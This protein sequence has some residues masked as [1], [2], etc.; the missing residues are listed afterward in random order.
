MAERNH[1]GYDGH[2]P[3]VYEYSI[4]A[5][6]LFCCENISDKHVSR[7][8]GS[9]SLLQSTTCPSNQ[10]KAAARSKGGCY[11]LLP[12][13]LYLPSVP[14]PEVSSPPSPHLTYEF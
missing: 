14:E 7:M 1:N 8:A 4:S 2:A 13:A 10:S 6:L 9:Y 12:S 5:G 11:C 3:H